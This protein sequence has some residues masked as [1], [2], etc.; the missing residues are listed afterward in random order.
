MY[1]FNSSPYK[2]P[3]NILIARILHRLSN[4][5]ELPGH[6]FL[7]GLL[8]WFLYIKNYF[9]VCCELELICCKH[10]LKQEF[11]FGATYDNITGIFLFIYYSLFF[12]KNTHTHIYI[13]IYIYEKDLGTVLRCCSLSFPFKILPWRFFLMRRKYIF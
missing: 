12:Y 5:Q 8:K 3:R 4:I 7:K 1:N 6:I 10:E 9:P 2:S 11:L 13:Y